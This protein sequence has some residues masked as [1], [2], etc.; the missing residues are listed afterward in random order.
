[1]ASKA[2]TSLTVTAIALRA[3]GGSTPLAGKGAFVIG[4]GPEA[5]SA[6][7]PQ[8]AKFDTPRSSDLR[9]YLKNSVPITRPDQ[10]GYQSK[11]QEKQGFES[12]K[13]INPLPNIIPEIAADSGKNSLKSQGPGLDIGPFRIRFIDNIPSIPAKGG[14]FEQPKVVDQ[15]VKFKQPE[16]KQ[17]AGVKSE[18]E[19]TK[20]QEETQVFKVGSEVVAVK[21]KGHEWIEI[22]LLE[23]I[24]A[25]GSRRIRAQALRRFQPAVSP[26]AEHAVE[27]SPL[28]QPATAATV[29]SEYLTRVNTESVKS[30][31][32]PI[33]VRQVRVKT[34]ETGFRNLSSEAQEKRRRYI[35]QDFKVNALRLGTLLKNFDELK[36]ES[37]DGE[38]EGKALEKR[39]FIR[40]A[41]S[42]RSTLIERRY[43]NKP[44]GGQE[45]LGIK[46]DS[47][48]RVVRGQLEKMVD[49]DTAVEA[50]DQLPLKL[51]TTEQVTNVLTPPNSPVTYY[52][53][54]IAEE[55]VETITSRTEVATQAF[56]SQRVAEPAQQ[57]E[58][59]KDELVPDAESQGN[60]IEPN[61]SFIQ[62]ALDMGEIWDK[63]VG[64]TKT[65][66]QR[67]QLFA[68]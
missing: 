36:A 52:E 55:I 24:I 4:K 51:A 1:M 42:L 59:V 11:P 2:G 20:P 5:G 6:V 57:Q 8:A 41:R 66:I 26:V 21:P 25:A 67:K 18:A 9:N 29:R 46:L 35:G 12:V 45:R 32:R 68:D 54:V 38:V 28:V 39:S 10:I 33:P 22:G 27:T 7:P 15:T 31:V 19:V 58:Q 17:K 23:Q 61:R 37:A 44:D 65:L 3:G 53:P 14:D 50:T 48:K 43:K 60:I 34:H 62:S 56:D 40:T 13:S 49:D 64:S 16:V 30:P 47:L 63:I